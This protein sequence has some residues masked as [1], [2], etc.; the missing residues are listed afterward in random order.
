MLRKCLITI[1]LSDALAFNLK[2]FEENIIINAILI[3]IIAT[4][5]FYKFK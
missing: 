1:S 4:F 5:I 3:T 2:N